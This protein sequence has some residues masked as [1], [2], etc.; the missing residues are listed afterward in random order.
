MISTGTIAQWKHFVKDAQE[1]S[2]TESPSIPVLPDT[3]AKDG[4]FPPPPSKQFFSLKY[5]FPPSQAVLFFL[6]GPPFQANVI[7]LPWNSTHPFLF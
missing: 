2:N 4:K 1:L 5:E 6:S 3:Q 7:F